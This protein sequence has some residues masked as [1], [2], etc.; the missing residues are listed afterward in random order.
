VTTEELRDYLLQ[1]LPMF[2]S[3]AMEPAGVGYHYT[4][5]AAEIQ[6]AE[7]M[8]GAPINEHLAGTQRAI[9]STRASDPKGVVFAYFLLNTAC[10]MAPDCSIPWLGPRC[11]VFR[12]HF[13]EAVSAE[14]VHD[15]AVEGRGVRQLLIIADQIS[16]FDGLGHAR[17]LD[18]F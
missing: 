2:A 18:G 17:D 5:Y 9:R 6:Q 14:H 4:Q 11:D 7:R 16:R 15:G 1:H 10:R 13:R 3:P 8:L 12:L